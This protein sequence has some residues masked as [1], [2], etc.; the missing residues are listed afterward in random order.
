LVIGPLQ[1]IITSWPD[2]I[3][4]WA[5]F[6]RLDFGIA[7]GKNKKAAFR[8]DITLINPEGLQWLDDNQHLLED[9]EALFVDESTLFKG[10]TRKRTK[11]LKRTLDM[12]DR[13]HIMT[14]TPVPRTC[15]DWF[16]QQFIVD[17]GD[18]FGKGITKFKKRYFY[19]TGYEMRD[20]APFEGT[21]EKMVR[22]AKSRF[23]VA[24]NKDLKLPGVHFLDVELSL[25]P[26]AAKVYKEMERKLVVKYTKNG[27][28][29]KK[30]ADNETDK[31]GKLRQIASGA[32]YDKEE[33]GKPRT[34]QKIHDVKF[35]RA[36]QI[37][38]EVGEPM[39]VLFNR[40]FEATEMKKK[41]KGLR[42]GELSGKVPVKDRPKIKKAWNNKELDVLLLHP[43][44][45]AHGLNLQHGGSQMMWLTLTDNSEYYEQ[46][47]ARLN[48]LGAKK[49]VVIY[50]LVMKGTVEK[51]VVLKRLLNRE[52][53]QD[54]LLEYCKKIQK[55]LM[56]AAR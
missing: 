12:F 29:I 18:S 54:F 39:V 6:R 25:P 45:G 5:Q 35:E 51:G 26:K 28:P 20:W 52:K 3:E 17:Q 1:T 16:S 31:Y 41:L 7:H 32:L 53:D 44:S 38:E 43:Q 23:F 50:R 27:K 34:Y 24:E 42:I 4:K 21:H 2:E 30:T 8:H 22:M 11:Y 56:K 37:I 36:R 10:F 15:L 9:K 46:A 55:Q 47:N 19:P 13:R 48:R 49:G 33:K 14:G 40:T